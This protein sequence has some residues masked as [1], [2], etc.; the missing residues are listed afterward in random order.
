L[1]GKNYFKLFFVWREKFLRAGA[2]GI[3]APV[4]RRDVK[5]EELRGVAGDE[6]TDSR[7]VIKRRL[8]YAGRAEAF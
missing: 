5:G 1:D 8:R 6:Q 3:K 4:D 7:R 2:E